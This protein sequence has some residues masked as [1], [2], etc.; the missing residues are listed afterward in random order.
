VDE[1]LLNLLPIAGGTTGHPSSDLRLRADSSNEQLQGR[2]GGDSTGEHVRA[3]LPVPEQV[4]GLNVGQR[5]LAANKIASGVLLQNGAVQPVPVRQRLG[6]KLSRSS[7]LGFRVLHSVDLRNPL[8]P[9][10]CNAIQNQVHLRLLLG[11]RP[12]E[13]V[14][15]SE[16]ASDGVALNEA[17]VA[18]FQKRDLAECQKSGLPER[19]RNIFETNVLK[20]QS[21]VAKAQTGKLAQTATVEVV[22]ANVGLGPLNFGSGLSH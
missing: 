10:I 11:G 14:F 18:D 20:L 12:I 1:T 22:Q 13:I 9:E 6:A 7:G 4:E 15:A 2:E 8:A 3:I 17:E 19:I 21:C 16:V 5:D